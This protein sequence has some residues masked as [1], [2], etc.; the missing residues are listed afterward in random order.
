M[1]EKKYIQLVEAH[2]EEMIRDLQTLVRI[3][4]VDELGI[5]GQPV[6]FGEGVQQVFREM[7]AMGKREGFD[8]FNADNYGGH[9]EWKAPAA[10]GEV[11]EVMAIL[12][13]LDVV[14]EGSGWEFEPYSA[15]VKDGRMYGRGT[16]DNKG[17]LIAGLYAMKAV[18]EAGYVPKKTVR[19]IMGL[20][21]ETNWDGMEKY[22]EAAGTPDFGFTPDGEFPL[23][24]GEKGVLTFDIAAKFPKT[25]GGAKGLALRSIQGG[26]ASNSVPDF[27]KAL[28]FCE[29]GYEEI[30]ARA[31]EFVRE[32]GHKLACKGRGK[33]LEIASEGVSAHGAT[34][35]KGVNAIAILMKFLGQLNFANEGVGDFIDFFNRYIGAQTNGADMGCGFTDE[36]SGDLVWNTGVIDMTEEAVQLTI[37]IRYP[38][39]CTDDQIYEAMMPL[40]NQYGYGIVKGSHNAPI[41]L[42]VDHPVVSS[43]MAAYQEF[44][45]DTESKPMIIGGAS[46]ARA[47]PNAVC[48]GMLFPGEEDIMHQKNESLDL[49]NMVKATKIFAEAIVRLTEAELPE[50]EAAE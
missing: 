41:Y 25:A 39:S 49:D 18:K 20:D 33:S 10:D 13:H 46:Y 21:E 31:A 1:C 3:K 8:T 29:E 7:L 12:G 34:P 42:P 5:H 37:N 11:P 22:L 50:A 4:S 24:H 28:V 48:F 45:G 15:E 26:T 30:R 44:T 32:T 2:R 38:I 27:A 6:P 17:P 14:P 43:L 47:I 9:I 36:V 40:I 35:W 16:S 19:M 23:I